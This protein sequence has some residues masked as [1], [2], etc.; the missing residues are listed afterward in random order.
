MRTTRRV[1]A[2]VLLALAISQP[3]LA[4]T[5]PGRSDM[6][7]TRTD[8]ARVVRTGLGDMTT[9][10]APQRV[11]SRPAPTPHDTPWL[12]ISVAPVLLI[13]AAVVNRST[14]RVRRAGV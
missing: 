10:R 12:L 11:A 7:L 3:A 5:R 14:R 1:L 9:P 4:Q 6:S 2:T 13:A 8:T